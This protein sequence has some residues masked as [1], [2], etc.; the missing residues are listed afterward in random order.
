MS[1]RVASAVKVRTNSECL[2]LA[3]RWLLDGF[4]SSKIAFRADCTWTVRLLA[5]TSLLWALAQEST[6]VERFENSRRIA[7]HLFSGTPAGSYQA[8]IKL[9]VRW[10]AVMLEL[11]KEL[12]RERMRADLHDCM[13]TAGFFVF[14][15]DGSKIDLPRTVS[16]QSA[17]AHSRK[18]CK[19]RKD[20]RRSDLRKR[21][22]P[23]LFLTTAWHVGTGL[24]WDWRRGPVDSSERA[25]LLEMLDQLPKGALITADAG[26]TGYSFLERILASGRR[27]LIRV[28]SNVR[29]LKELG[30][31]RERRDTVYLW[32]DQKVDC[33]G[34]PL[35][36]R[37]IESRSG[38]EPVY[39][40][41]DLSADELDDRG[42]VE[43]YARRWGVEVFYR[44]FKQTF[45][46]RKLRS[47][48]AANAPV[49]LDW[50]LVGLWALS[51]YALVQA[52]QDR[53]PP[54]R[55]S[56]AQTLRCIRRT[57]RDYLHP[58]AP[59]ERLTCRLRIALIDDYARSNKQ[60]RDYPKKRRIKPPGT[61]RIRKAT[62]DQRKLARSIRTERLKYG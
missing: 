21:E 25:H 30:Y 14:G 36:F 54:R 57:V 31:V 56:C 46:H 61:P 38:K 41:T 35:P 60:S 23:Q 18:Q 49:E 20:R 53:I 19:K 3:F 17:Y 1:H 26:F 51:L 27:V 7:T 6:L 55:L 58:C 12:L 43:I 40:L 8:F 10:T 33:G 15:V 13:R 47:T 50:S 45:G 62:P 11:L 48:S 59:T 29:L 4:E 9:L 28:G 22:S 24:P 2:K 52:R 32:P 42:V 5:T 37:L 34:P 44:G 39:L 16:H